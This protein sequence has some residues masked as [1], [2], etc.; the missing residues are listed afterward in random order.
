[1]EIDFNKKAVQWACK[2][3]QSQEYE[4]TSQ[5]PEIVQETPWSY[6]SRFYSSDGFIYLKRTPRQLSFE[7]QILQVL[8]NQFHQPVPRVISYNSTLDCFLM[9]DAGRSLRVLLKQQFDPQFLIKAVCQFTTMQLVVA[10]QVEIFLE[11][12]IPDWR[13]ERLP[14]LY[15]QLLSR[16]DI[17]MADGLSIDEIDTLKMLLPKVIH[18]CQQIFTYSIPPSIVQ[19]DFNDNNTLINERTLN[20]TFIDL[21][22]IVIT[23]PFFSFLNFLK[24]IKKHY[25]Q[26]GINYPDS[27][28]IDSFLENFSQ[29]ES[30]ENLTKSFELVR[31]L[32]PIYTALSYIR[33]MD[34][35]G[36]KSLDKFYGCGRL[37]SALLHFISE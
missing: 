5:D 13:L 4:L 12:G 11:L 25:Y 14:D 27:A 15:I 28:L 33:L 35:C 3:L 9:E 16:K 32:E 30:W 6:V 36:T 10:D 37:R 22:E 7:A 18:L 26:I 2:I 34:I 20:L 31:K 23:H 17:L 21:G 24:A 19:P 1:M 29:L 8:K